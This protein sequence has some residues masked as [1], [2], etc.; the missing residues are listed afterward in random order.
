LAK[1]AT[2]VWLRDKMARDGNPTE[3]LCT[4]EAVPMDRV[5]S[6][7]VWYRGAWVPVDSVGE[8]DFDVYIA[9]RPDVYQRARTLANAAAA[10]FLAGEPTPTLD[11]DARMLL[12]DT[13]VLRLQ[14]AAEEDVEALRAFLDEMKR[15]LLAA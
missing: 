3:W 9:E 5:R 13:T 8:D 1:N 15:A 10:K 7:D 14:D 11:S 6:I 2:P 12:E 4:D